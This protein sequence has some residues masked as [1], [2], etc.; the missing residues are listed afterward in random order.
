MLVTSARSIGS[1]SHLLPPQC[2]ELMPQSFKER[3]RIAFARMSAC[4]TLMIDA[5][6]SPIPPFCA[7]R[8]DDA[9]IGWIADGSTRP[10]R[11]DSISVVVHSQNRWADTRTDEGAEQVQDMMMRRR[12]QAADR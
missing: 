12:G 11:H 5:E 2:L 8:F 1:S 7:V 4:F 9:V 10:H 3:D 6:R